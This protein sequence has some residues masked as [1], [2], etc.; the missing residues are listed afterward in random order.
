MEFAGINYLAVIVATIAAFV[1]GAVY[2]GSLSKP[3]MKAAKIE[4]DPNMSPK[5]FIVT[6]LCQL[7]LAYMMA[8]LLGHLDV[9][10]LTGGLTTGFFVWI[11]FIA[12]TVTVNQ[13]Y[14]GFNWDLTIIDCGHWLGT[15]L[16]TGGI[17]G[18][19]G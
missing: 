14:Q 10:T 13:R 15:A 3:W 5:L 16:I 2:Y 4:G 17:I 8:G 11:G 18:A 7:V 12:T 6:G 9:L 19:F 1:F